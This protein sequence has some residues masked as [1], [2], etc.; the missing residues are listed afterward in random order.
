MMFEKFTERGR[1]VIVYARE[2]AERLQNDYLGTEHLLLGTL[3]EEDGIPV[4]ALRKMGVDIEQM[5]MEV[6][7]NLPAGGNTLTFGDIPFTPR[8]KKVLE[9]AVEA[10]GKGVEHR[11][12]GCAFGTRW[13]PSVSA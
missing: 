11:P 13:G 2:E 6:E 8:A 12:N 7:R 5:R 3:R 4:A 10:I 1:K 9:Y